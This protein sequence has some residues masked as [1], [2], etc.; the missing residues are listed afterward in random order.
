MVSEKY[1]GIN[2][3]LGVYE[4]YAT[5][6]SHMSLPY[7]ASFYSIFSSLDHSPLL[8]VIDYESYGSEK[9]IK[10]ILPGFVHPNYHT[11]TIYSITDS[12]TDG[13][14]YYVGVDTKLYP[15][16]GKPFDK[17]EEAREF[18][19]KKTKDFFND[20]RQGFEGDYFDDTCDG[21]VEISMSSEK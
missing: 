15:E 13:E 17:Y 4:S 1:E 10:R 11:I 2:D 18:V 14:E 20:Y 8:Y 9:E 5:I 16:N 19:E 6:T 3:S 21:I 7:R 12:E